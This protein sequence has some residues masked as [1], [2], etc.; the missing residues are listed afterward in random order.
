M[1][2]F[3]LFVALLGASLSAGAAVESGLWYDRT[4]DGH[5]LD[6]HRQGSVLFGTFYTYDARN[7]VEWLW[8]QTQDTDA[9]VSALS[10]F[11]RDVAGQV[12]GTEV[13]SISLTPVS[14]CPDGIAR[15]G[16]RT[17][18]RMDFVLDERPATWCVEPLLPT[19]RPP[20]ALLSGAWYDPADPGWGLMTHAYSG[21]DGGTQTFRI[22]YFH[23][24]AGRPRW[25]F[26]VTPGDAL[27]QSQTFYTPY[28][29]CTDCSLSPP[30]TIPIG[31]ATSTL[32]E[33][34]AQADRDRNHIELSLAFEGELPFVKSAPLAMLSNPLRVPGAAATAQG[35]VAGAVVAST[36]VERYMNIPYA[37]PPLGD[38]RWRAPQPAVLRSHLASAHLP[39]VECPQPDPGEEAQS[40]DCLQLNVWRPSTPGPHP[41]MVWI[42]GGGLTNGS[43]V[44][45]DNDGLLYDGNYYAQRGIVFVSINYRLGLL[46]FLA[47]RD[48]VGEA[49]DHPQ[50]GN[51]G[52]QDQVAALQWVQRNITSFGGD[53]A[54][55]TIFGESAGGVSACALMSAPSAR[56]LFQAA[57][58]T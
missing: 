18:L 47:Q 28:V 34:L 54:R 11:T 44:Q 4:R 17:L 6:L 52:L 35:P 50:T 36:G 30:L 13:G 21:S 46:G 45:R 8:I 57:S 27:T 38:L 25:A 55:V 41:V 43:S 29:E 33:P 23:D 31:T 19:L 42:H 32:S 22:V 20:M 16:A 14:A 2:R 40:E 48:F 1:P 39:G 37:Q 10:R 7:A 5:G 12:S 56:G 49:V 15:P 51:Y 26:S 9:P 58:F 53:P 24:R 3:P